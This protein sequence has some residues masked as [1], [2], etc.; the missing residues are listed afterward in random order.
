VRAFPPPA[1]GQAGQWQISN[2]GKGRPT[3][4]MWLRNGRDLIYRS[5]DQL[6]AVSYSVNGDAFVPEKPRV[7]IDKLGGIDSGWDVKPDGKRV[8]VVTPVASGEAPKPDH[9]V[10]L[11][12]NFFDELRR[13]VPVE[14]KTPS[15]SAAL[16]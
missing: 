1:S 12:L 15:P 11:L 13:R 7:W 14:N 6:M 3:G 16:V 8:A 10:V 9:E 2:D 5:G 4:P